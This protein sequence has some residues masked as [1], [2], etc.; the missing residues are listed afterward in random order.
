[1]AKSNDNFLPFVLLGVAAYLLFS[2]KP[3]AATP[4]PVYRT[5]DTNRA[6]TATAGS[7]SPSGSFFIRWYQAVLN[8]LIGADLEIDGIHGPKTR[9]AVIK[10]QNMWFLRPDGIVGPETEYYLKSA[11]GQE[12]YTD[13]PYT[14]S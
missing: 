10:F 5:P 3:V 4:A 9:E 7:I 8:Q 2:K 14:A 12:G 11:M 6:T 1:M 13:L